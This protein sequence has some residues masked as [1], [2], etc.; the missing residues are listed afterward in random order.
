[1]T[2]TLPVS[3]EDVLS[4]QERI[5]SLVKR[6]PVLTCSTIDEMAG[7][8]L[9]FK[10]ENFQ[11]VGAFKFRGACNAVLSLE[12][13][14]ISQGVA[15]HSSGNHAQAVA[16]AARMRGVAAHIVMIESSPEVK[17]R[18]VR[19]YGARV[20]F[21]K[22]ITERIPT[23]NRIVAETGAVY[24]GSSN[25][26]RVIAGQGTMGLELMEQAEG[27]DAI[28]APVGG[29]GMMSGLCIAAKGIK[30]NI[31][32]FGAEPEGAND[33]KL[34]LESGK[35]IHNKEVNT[36]CDGLRT[37]LG[38]NT[39]AIMHKHVEKIITV[40]DDQVRDAMRLI[41]E[42]MKIVVEPSGAIPLAVV[43]TEEFK[44][45]S[46]IERV[47]I[48]LSGGNIDLNKW[49]WKSPTELNAKRE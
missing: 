27:L 18:A 14:E 28:V 40:S 45:L 29:G 10:C 43:L 31:R 4:A 2:N 7:R 30:K 37:N 21:C 1:M 44:S 38:H 35:I 39:F 33:A 46:G 25:D 36:I 20:V 49:S 22:G 5:K 32:M 34:S 19:G 24:I 3:F 15:T 13:S 17:V 42:R 26:V 48:V 23:C 16:L 8:K 9:F 12:D 41:W 6:T 11:K 47:G